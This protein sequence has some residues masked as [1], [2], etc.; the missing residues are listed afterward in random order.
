MKKLIPLLFFFLLVGCSS[1][2]DEEMIDN[3]RH[4]MINLNQ[5]HFNLLFKVTGL[6]VDDDENL[7]SGIVCLR[8]LI[9]E[10]SA[11][12]K[13]LNLDYKKYEENWK[14]LVK[15]K[16]SGINMPIE[17]LTVER[18]LIKG[19]NSDNKKLIDNAR[20]EVI[21]LN[22]K[23]NDLYF[24]VA[25]LS[26]KGDKDYEAGVVCL[27]ELTAEIIAVNKALNIDC[28][29]YDEN[30]KPLMQQNSDG[31]KSPVEILPNE[32]KIEY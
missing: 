32:L 7:M 12:N 19:D 5:K 10:I 23:H 2:N 26:M 21:K 24:K 16:Y 22:Q 31:T 8:E 29:L 27:Q 9:A 28:K 17:E 18:L 20:R 13:A 14:T 6:C 30:G 11:V 3:A 4:E 1:S 25:S 15:Q